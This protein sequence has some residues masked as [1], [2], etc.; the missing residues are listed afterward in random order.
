MSLRKTLEDIEKDSKKVNMSILDDEPENIDHSNSQNKVVEITLKRTISNNNFSKTETFSKSTSINFSR[1]SEEDLYQLTPAAR[2]VQKYQKC[3]NNECDC[4]VF[5][6]PT[7]SSIQQE[8]KN[9]KKYEE[10]MERMNKIQ[11]DILVLQKEE[12]EPVAKFIKNK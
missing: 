8:G 3:V 5:D 1:D 10:L 9:N 7:S 6:I 4:F 11:E 2:W 12:G